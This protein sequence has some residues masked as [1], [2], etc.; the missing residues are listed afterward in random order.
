DRL[1]YV[2]GAIGWRSSARILVHHALVT[3]RRSFAAA[4]DDRLRGAVP[5]L[6][7]ASGM[8][9]PEDRAFGFAS[10]ARMIEILKRLADIKKKAASAMEAAFYTVLCPARLRETR[11]CPEQQSQPGSR[12]YSR[13][14][15]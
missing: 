9:Y 8:I 5:Q 10:K 11:R 2:T 6:R 3:A 12:A 4:Q 7:I 13:S 14:E 1:A 15:R